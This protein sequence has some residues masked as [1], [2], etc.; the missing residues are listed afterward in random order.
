MKSGFKIVVVFILAVLSGCRSDFDLDLEQVSPKLVINALVS[1]DSV[2][3][4]HLTTEYDVLSDKESEIPENATIILIE[5]DNLVATL[6]KNGNYY[7]APGFYV[8]VGNRYQI[9]ASVAGFPDASADVI[10][11][12]PVKIIS[13]DT[14]S[15]IEIDNYGTSMKYLAFTIFF[16]D[17]G[18]N[19]NYYMLNT[20]HRVLNNEYEK[21]HIFDMPFETTSELIE[22]TYG[23]GEII[24]PEI[25][26]NRKVGL[27]KD[28][29][30]YA[31][32]MFFSNDL[33]YGKEA[34]IQIM[35][36]FNRNLGVSYLSQVIRLYSIDE[37][38]Y[39]YIKTYAVYNENKEIPVREPIEV[40]SNIQGGLGI[41]GAQSC[42]ADSV[43]LIKN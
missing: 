43:V 19:T 25:S 12:K 29:K 17:P 21:E 23:W 8:K 40:Y 1:P 39:R 11:P 2:F 7:I 37:N 5:N 41:F 6:V 9:K 33:I 10:V 20:F 22:Y 26:N 24:L 28:N 16:D 36:K 27:K 35:V 30:I 4:V 32:G 38:Y 13:I 31:Y 15:F 34:K 3:T 18:L 14:S 42:S